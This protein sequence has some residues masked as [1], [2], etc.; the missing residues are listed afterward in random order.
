MHW[1]IHDSHPSVDRNPMP[2][3]Y[4]QAAVH[5]YGGL[6]LEVL[7]QDLKQLDFR[8]VSTTSRIT[9][10]CDNHDLPALTT[11]LIQCSSR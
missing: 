9:G 8:L 2:P 7:N 5:D 1:H 4:I 11:V 3:D 10:I 6:L